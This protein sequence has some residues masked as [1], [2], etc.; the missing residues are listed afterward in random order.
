MNPTILFY[1]YIQKK[2]LYI[3]FLYTKVILINLKSTL[4]LIILFFFNSNYKY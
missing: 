1:N 3:H 4:N 2:L